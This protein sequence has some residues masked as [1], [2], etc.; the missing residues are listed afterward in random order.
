MT[1]TNKCSVIFKYKCKDINYNK[2]GLVGCLD[3]L[4]NW[5]INNPV[6]LD[7]NEKES[8]YISNSIELPK[9]EFIEYKYVFHHNNNKKWEY[10]PKNANRR[11]KLET[12]LPQYI[13][14]KEDDP[15]TEILKILK[16]PI[17]FKSEIISNE[18]VDFVN[19]KIE[20]PKEGVRTK[21]KKKSKKKGKKK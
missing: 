10:L 4:K 1:E 9:N 5:D 8:I 16:P 12:N 17:F 3:I 20:E 7:Y 21:I 11:I 14:D 6:F 2:V 13:L 15:K 18:K 19:M